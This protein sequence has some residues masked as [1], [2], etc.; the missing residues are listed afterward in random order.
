MAQVPDLFEDLKHCY[1]EIEEYTSNNDDLSQNQKPFY[2]TSCSP[3]QDAYMDGFISLSSAAEI[4]KTARCSFKESVSVVTT[5]GKVVK[6][7]RLDFNETITDE[8]LQAIANDTEEEIIE[9]MSAM[10]TFQ[11]KRNYYFSNILISHCILTNINSQSLTR[12]PSNSNL[13]SIAL[14]N[15]DDAERFDIA[16]Y[17][18]AD[19]I[20]RIPVLLRISDTQL[21]VSGQGEN[22]PVV[23][24]KMPEMPKVVPEDSD[25]L[26]LV[27]RVGNHSYF[28]SAA[29][30]DLFLA[31]RDEGL[32]HLARGLPSIIDFKPPE[33][34][35][36]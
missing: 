27:E 28:R 33:A 15:L 25:L 36:V 12:D 8:D 35:E 34:Y 21:F 32:V 5:K 20:Y 1:S 13:R 30:P 16:G 11:N 6:K 19:D 22:E 31:T 24:K 14:Q 26:F 23:L 2:D 3:L 10:N 4:S 9:P 18:P 29:Y 7:R 17:K